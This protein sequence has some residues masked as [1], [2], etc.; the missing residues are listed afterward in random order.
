MYYKNA[1]LH[2]LTEEMA[3]QISEW[4]YKPPLD[5]Y[6][7]KGRPNGYLMDKAT[8]GTEQ[9]CL[10]EQA[11]LIGYVSC[12]L[13]KD[14]LGAGRPLFPKLCGRGEGHLFAEKCVQ[15][16]RGIK[17]YNDTVYLRAAASNI[18]AVK[19]YKRAGFVLSE[20]IQ[21]EIADTNNI[22]DFW[23]MKNER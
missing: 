21:D 6:S 11:R 5:M 17:H 2:A 19:A 10:L 8:W 9:F 18:R 20:I 3:L 7:F 4:E 16:I 1:H 15:E 12:R 22:E 14:M 13:D 23:V